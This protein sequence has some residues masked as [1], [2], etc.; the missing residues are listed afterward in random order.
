MHVIMVIDAEYPSKDLQLAV[1]THRGTALYE[2][3]VAEVVEENTQSDMYTQ[4]TR[5][6]TSS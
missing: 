6:T 2:T 5:N 1:A 3:Y 4:N